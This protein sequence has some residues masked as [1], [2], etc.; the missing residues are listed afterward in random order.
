MASFLGR[1]LTGN[2]QDEVGND[3]GMRV[4]GTRLKHTMG[5]VSIKLYDKRGLVLR[6][7]TTVND[8]SFS[9]HYHKVEQRGG[10]TTHKVAPL[11][12]SIYRLNP[13]LRELLSAANRRSL[14]FLSDLDDLSAGLK[15]LDKL[16]RPVSDNGYTLKGF[17]FFLQSDQSVFEA[18]VRGEFTISGLRNRN[19]P[20]KRKDLN[21][22]QISRCLKRLRTH[23]LIKKIGRTDKYYHTEFGRHVVLTDLKRRELVVIPALCPSG[24]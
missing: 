7:E 19:L 4:G 9:S 6:I 21:S 3:L 16:A 22:G 11:K 24:A 20:D 13:D 12:K 17:N 1:K 23:G 15:A 10:T 18:L 14:D 2:F 8:V 5:P